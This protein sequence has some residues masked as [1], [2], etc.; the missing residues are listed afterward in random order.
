MRASPTSDDRRAARNQGSDRFCG[1]CGTQRT[2]ESHG[3]CGACGASLDEVDTPTGS[4]GKGNWWKW[5]VLAGGI[6][7]VVFIAIVVISD[8][9]SSGIDVSEL[10]EGDCFNGPVAEGIDT[11]EFGVVDLASC[12]AEWQY[13]VIDSFIV[14]EGGSYPEISYFDNQA[15]LRCDRHTAVYVFPLRE[16]W[17]MGDREVTCI[18]DSYGLSTTDPE[19]ISRIVSGYGLRDGECL[20]ISSEY[21]ELVPCSGTWEVKV[22]HSFDVEFQGSYPG[23]AYFEQE[24]DQRCHSSATNYF[25]PDQNTW[26]QGDRT[27]NCLQEP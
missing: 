8:S 1:N 12:S 24:F 7:G 14:G 4:S 26:I 23:D 3:F 20:N 18:Q 19:K 5:L 2:S 16:S 22:I 27:V 11:I 17:D 15:R 21:T 13:R 25:P 10:R 9:D 6:V